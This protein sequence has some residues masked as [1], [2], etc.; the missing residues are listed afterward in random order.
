M[1]Y[2]PSNP[3]GQNTMANSSPVAI[4]S[5]QSSIPVSGTFWQATQP[6]SGAFY[7]A[8]QPVSIAS[9]PTHGVTGT[10]WQA[11]QPVSNAGT[12]AVQAA[13]SGTWNIGSITTLPALPAGSN[14]IGDVDVLSVVPGI[15]ATNLGKQTDSAAGGT[16]TGV[17]ILAIRDDALTTLT[18]ADGDYTRFRVN[19]I[20][21][22][23]ASATIDTALPAGAN[24]IGSITNTTF[25]STQSGTWTVQPGNTVNTTPW[26][27]T[28][29]PNGAVANALTNATTTAYASSLI[30]KASAGVLYMVNGFN[31][32]ATS[33]FI[34]I[35][36]SA[37]VPADAA[38]PKITFYVAALSNFSL[39]L[40]EYGRYFAAGIV[41]ANSSTGPTK[42]LGAADCWFDTQ[43]K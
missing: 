18:P 30:I 1:A 32:K 14:N 39:D 35:H 6:V 7:Q 43:Y 38:A 19:S 3:N 13:Q 41:I 31:S 4:A 16:D 21:R 22:L 8:T 29:V 15:G 17:A 26:L 36:D 34:Q 23:W 9:V 20:G 42:T 37:T 10:F 33:Q 40:G 28:E 2:T 27:T 11:T 24:A 5:N 25:A 12:F